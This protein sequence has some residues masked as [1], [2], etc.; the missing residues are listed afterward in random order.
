M[1]IDTAAFWN[2]SHLNRHVNSVGATTYQDY[3]QTFNLVGDFEI[4][5]KQSN[6]VLDIGPGLGNF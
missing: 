6:T 1:M 5:I 3:L 2:K 4:D